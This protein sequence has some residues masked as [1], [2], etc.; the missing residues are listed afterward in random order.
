MVLRFAADLGDAVAWGVGGIGA[1]LFVVGILVLL[2]RGGILFPLP[3]Q[4][5]EG[6]TRPIKDYYSKLR[7]DDQKYLGH[8]LRIKEIGIKVDRLI[9]EVVDPFIELQ[10]SLWNWSVFNV[11]AAEVDG[12]LS[13]N[14]Q[15]MAG[16]VTKVQSTNAHHG[17]Y[18]NVKVR[19]WVSQE[20]AK[21]LRDALETGRL[22]LDISTLRITFD[23][24][25]ADA[26][27]KFQFQ[28]SHQGTLAFTK[29]CDWKAPPLGH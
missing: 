5:Q 26:D 20:R 23:A 2:Y 15:E 24:W 18:C 1:L 10:L 6:G 7:D 17:H 12:H 8:R 22:D 16:D 4:R 19:Q 28:W 27:T 25:L 9:P 29:E 13:H 14:G 3:F 11:F 21:A